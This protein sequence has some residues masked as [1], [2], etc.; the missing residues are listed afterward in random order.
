VPHDIQPDEA[1]TKVSQRISDIKQVF[2][3]NAILIRKADDKQHIARYYRLNR[4]AYSLFNSHKGFVHMGIS[5]D[6]VFKKDDFLEHARIISH[7]IDTASASQVLE[8]ATGKGATVRHLAAKYPLVS[9]TGLDLPNGQLN[10]HKRGPSNLTLHEGDYHDLGQ[11]ADSS[12]DAVYIIEALC[13]ARDKQQVANEVRRILKPGGYFIVFDGYCSKLPSE[14]TET[15]RLANELTF[16]SM[17]VQSRDHHYKSFTRMLTLAGMPVVREE[18]LSQAV[19]PTAHRIERLAQRF[20][21]HPRRARLI[22]K[23]V[24]QEVT[25]NAI[26]GYLMPVT[27]GSGLHQYWL[28]V[29]RKEQ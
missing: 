14:S 23:L 28:T 20:F 10:I 4:I 3:I 17:M 25:A 18:D 8:L 9:F 29:A 13:H 7:A 1:M 6:G 12:F 19:M 21:S 16:K 26:A 15:E 27:I 24:P 11:Y 5:R 22:N 2:D